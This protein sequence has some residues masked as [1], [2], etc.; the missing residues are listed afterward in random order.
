M[1]VWIKY[2]FAAIFG[3]ICAFILPSG[4]PSVA[5]TINFL[6]EIVIR[7]GRYMVIPVIFFTGITAYNRLRE[8]KLLVKTS[9]WTA[10]VIAVSSLI[11]TT[12]GLI[13][14]LVVKLPRI[15]ITVENVTEATS[16][17]VE[18][19]LR[20]LF[21][22]S[23]FETLG[24]GTFIFAA[25]FF[26]LL[27]GCASTSDPVLF[28]PATTLADSLSKLMYN[29]G[30]I[31]T[32]FLAYGMIAILCYWTIQF[33]AI[34]LSGVFTPM[35]IM[36]LVDLILVAGVIYP[37]IIRYLCHDP[38][39]YRILYASLCS[40]IASFFSGD[41][42]FT[43]LINMRHGKESLGIRRRINGAVHPIFTIFARGGSALVTTVGFIMIWRSYSS[44][45]IPF[46][47]ILWILFTSFGIS[48]LLGGFPSGGAF[49]SLTVLCTLYSN[50]FETGFL[51]L[52]PAAP[53]ICSFAAAFDALTAMFGTYI[54]AVKTKLIEHHGIKHFI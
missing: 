10:S 46:T 30:I 41:S 38:H 50:G 32:E 54:I 24:N 6:M 53:I 11:L 26:A 2:L 8:N 17:N 47:D 28:K 22:Y 37:L 48:F 13:S 52:K 23:A 1:K 29:I 14:I 31:F 9:V 5:A 27:I 15:P 12:V 33:R 40:L 39:P 35:I 45:P 18:K 16:L 44:L 20:L 51:L 49:I 34:I 42:N 21:P 36:F 25:Y 19:L 3:I 4:N 43:L 7:F